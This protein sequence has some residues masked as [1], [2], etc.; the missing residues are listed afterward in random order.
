[1]DSYEIVAFYK[2]SE[3]EVSA[4]AVE[5]STLYNLGLRYEKVPRTEDSI[6]ALLAQN[7]VL[8]LFNRSVFKFGKLMKY[9]Y[10][11]NKPVIVIH[12]NDSLSVYNNLKVPVGYLQE[13]KEKV[14][15]ANFFQRSNPNAKIELVIPK[16]KDEDIAFMVKNNVDFIENIFVKSN[17]TYVKTFV[18]GSFE[19]T[20]KSLFKNSE[21]CVIFVMRPFRVFSFYIPSNLRLFRKYSHTPTLI[22]PRDDELYIP[23]H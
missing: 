10:A 15:W 23:C 22:I 17:A 3:Q 21:D 2:D 7:T 12:L 11:L 13:N 6:K 9:I 14:V 1:M 16:E 8:C 5:I 4:H 20:L 18:D 19:K